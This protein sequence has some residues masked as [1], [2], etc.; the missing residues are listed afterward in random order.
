M[1]T[2]KD[3]IVETKTGRIEGSIENGLSVFKGVPYAVPPVGELRWLPPQPLKPWEGVRPAKDFGTIAPQNLMQG[4]GMPDIPG[5]AEEEE[6]QS[7]DCLFLNVWTPG[8]DHA[9]RPVM[10][11]IH[12]GAFSIGSGSQSMFRG[13]RLASHGN[14]VLVTIN[15][16]LG[17]LG[18]LNLNELTKGKIPATGNE[19]LL[20]QVAALEWVR[21]NIAA[22]GGDP[23]N[24]TIFGE[25]AGGMSVGCLMNLPRA[26]G[27]FHKAIIESAVGDMARP[28]AP[29][30]KITEEF[31]R[32]IGIQA[33]DVAALRALPV[34]KLLHAQQETAIKTGQGM[35]PAIPVV[36]GIIMPKMP[37]ESFEAGLATRVPT[38]IGSNLE[39][40]KFFAMMNPSSRNLD[41]TGLTKTAERYVSAKDVHRL[42][43]TY[44]NARAKRGELTTP[45]EIF[46]AMNT[47]VMFRKVALRV[48][49]A[50]CKHA[51]ASYNYLFT[52][53]SPAAGG[54]LGACHALEIGFIFGTYDALFCGSGPDADK[55]AGQMQDAWVAFA[56][57]GNPSCKS[58]GTWPQYGEQRQTMILDKDSHVEK[59]AYEQERHVWDII[60]QVKI[61][62]MP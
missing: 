11:W 54:A 48:A 49:E 2:Q 22:F 37:L 21:D 45:F 14:I 32:I 61:G 41:E 25:S 34:A 31:L 18:F 9:K 56:R 20:D 57:T 12:G 3:L 43:E 52:W 38:L 42:I 29:S 13:G 59:A 58:L 53:K 51:P 23:N 36:D 28:L 39:E 16:R 19:G 24:I 30:V 17:V 50:Q 26:R 47:D 62:D 44:R 7:E 10:V 46:S 15:Y 1:S 33:N 5:F 35:A 60:G 6:P 4:P 40:E 55:L 8:I 27:L